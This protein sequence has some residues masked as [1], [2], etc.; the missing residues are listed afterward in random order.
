MRRVLSLLAVCAFVAPAASAADA[1]TP[2]FHMN[3]PVRWAAAEPFGGSAAFVAPKRE[4]DGFDENVNVV[5]APLEDQADFDSYNRR[6]L[7]VIQNGVPGARI[8]E[9]APDTLAGSPAWR[10][11]FTGFLGDRPMKWL[12]IWTLR[13]HRACVV[14]YSADEADYDERLSSALDA[15]RSLRF[16][17]AV[18]NGG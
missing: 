4:D 15:I 2:D 10:A 9:S 6:A 17:E 13:G 16:E 14:T 3:P 11:V 5:M 1:D 12:Q 18:Q 7:A 8:L